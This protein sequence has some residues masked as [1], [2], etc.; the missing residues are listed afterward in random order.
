[1]NDYEGKIL[2][3]KVIYNLD[4]LQSGRVKVTIPNVLEGS[5]N[6]LPWV[7][8]N[9]GST[10]YSSNVG[11][12]SIPEVGTYVSVKFQDG[13]PEFGVYTGGHLDVSTI[14]SDFKTNYPNRHGF[15]DSSGNKF[16]VD[17]TAGTITLTNSAGTKITVSGGEVVVE[18]S[19]T[20]ITGDVIIDKSLTVNQG[21]SVLGTSQMQGGLSAMGGITSGGI[22]TAPD[23]IG[24]GVSLAGE[25]SS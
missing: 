24:G 5:F 14:P 15:V 6:D 3:G 23:V 11:Y 2:K 1:M 17:R 4:P 13:D 21:F 19:I 8:P 22:I 9:T 25:A 18:N 16:I 7:C 10:G 12:V 20:H